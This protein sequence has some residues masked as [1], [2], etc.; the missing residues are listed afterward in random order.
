[1]KILILETSSEKGVIC[2]SEN[3][4]PLRSL[5]L[6]GGI[7]L[8]KKLALETA[9]LLEGEKPDLI[10]VGTGPGSYTG[11]RVAAA[12][13]QGLSVGWDAPLL[14]F[15]SLK[16]FAPQTEGDFT[17]LIDAR[18]PGFYAL[19]GRCEGGIYTFST[20][21]LLPPSA[22]APSPLFASPHPALIQKRFS[23]Q[24]IW[25]ETDPNPKLLA[26]L[27]YRQFLERGVEPLAYTYLSSP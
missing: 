27:S 22:I 18:T 21:A 26:E 6:S 2:L 23:T 13:A 10:A 20:P 15:C 1:M 9:A 11:I 8:S 7:E 19:Q 14:S 24:G 17:I 12:L 5:Q 4:I 25:R 16:G 3:E